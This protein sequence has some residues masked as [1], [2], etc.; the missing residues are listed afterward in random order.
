MELSHKRLGNILKIL[1]NDSSNKY[2]SASF[3]AQ[4]F[5]VSTRTIRN[6]IQELNK[7]LD[8]Y[9]V[10]I[11]NK[12]MAGFY[13]EGVSKQTRKR[14]LDITQ[15]KLPASNFL[16]RIQEIEQ[17][18]LVN[19]VVNITELTEQFFISDNTF[20]S[21]LVTIKK[22]FSKFDLKISKN[23]DNYFVEGSELAKR[24]FIITRLINKKANT[25]IVDFTEQ[26]KTIFYNVDLEL[27]K[28]IVHG[29]LRHYNYKITDINA[30]NIILHVA[31]SISRVKLGHHLDSSNILKIDQT[32]LNSL[33]VLS[34]KIEE[35]F[36]IKFNQNEAND[37]IYHFAINY[38]ECVTNSKFDISKSIEE[39]VTTFLTNIKVKFAIDLL[40]DQELHVNLIQHLTNLVK[41]KKMNGDRK[42]PLL[43]VIL[44][45]FPYAYE[46]TVYA[47]PVLEN[48]LKLHL[49]DDEVSFITL[50][51][52]AAVE[53][54]G[55][56]S[57]KKNVA[58]VCSTGASM[59]ALIKAKLQTQF[60][61]FINITG[62]YTY[63][64]Y[65]EGS[66]AN[67]DFLIA[68]VPLNNSPIPVIK[69]TNLVVGQYSTEY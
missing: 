62:T 25:Y 26:E 19:D 46:M 55:E 49:N 16:E 15:S 11:K 31:L 52:G 36:Q 28:Q 63:D 37:L 35:K 42:N 53:R 13:I 29:F 41:I 2:F 47:A 14:L 56:L 59:A 68:T 22:E 61:S 65:L 20:F 33:L 40:N 3:L 50:H 45:T 67:N 43:N 12:R 64:E 4:N 66:A 7:E 24:N 57:A 8:K 21:Y 51:I 23:Q 60:S 17:Y 30:K 18:L 69:H 58:L 6:D 1:L 39:A 5:G 54:Q 9:N 38:P 27:L 48:M 34:R 44:S 32:V 10:Q